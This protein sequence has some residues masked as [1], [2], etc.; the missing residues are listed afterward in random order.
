MSI[1]VKIESLE[2]VLQDFGVGYL[3]TVG[4]GRTK[5]VTVDAN[6]DGGVVRLPASRGSAANLASNPSASLLFPPP[7]P[8]GYALLIDGT[9]E[10][11]GD[12]ID[13]TPES[14]VLHR[15]ASH[16]DGPAA[17]VSAGDQTDCD[18][19]CRPV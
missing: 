2:A 11:D 18:N 1:P 5:V 12:G 14:A 9:A 10:A 19:D 8:R 15:P 16:A 7:A 17:P 4:D 6:L 13:F 3:L